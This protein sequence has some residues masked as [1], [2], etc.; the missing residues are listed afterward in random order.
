MCEIIRIKNINS[1]VDISFCSDDVIKRLD[2]LTILAS[3]I[4]VYLVNEE[5]MDE[6]YPPTKRISLSEEC[7]QRFF[8]DL[9]YP[10]GEEEIERFEKFIKECRREVVEK[11]FVAVGV[12]SKYHPP[13]IDDIPVKSPAI[14]IC[15]E[16]CVRW[17]KELDITPSFVFEKVYFHELAHAYMDEGKFTYYDEWWGRVI[18]ESLANAMVI[19]KFPDTHIEKIFR[20]ILSQPVEYKGSIFLADLSE[21]LVLF[22]IK[23]IYINFW[24]PISVNTLHKL[25]VM[26]K[27]LKRGYDYS[28]R[29]SRISSIQHYY[30]FS[31][32]FKVLAMNLLKYVV[33]GK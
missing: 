12:Y 23:D 22:E 33:T 4:P 19:K 9:E 20:I 31:T 7:L 21:Q 3:K 10:L 2:S 30:K 15:P 17:G 26:W 8:N 27:L 11:T 24:E 32:F 13:Y 14:F 1:S 16:R 25:F 6:L 28:I 18:E 5:T 29:L